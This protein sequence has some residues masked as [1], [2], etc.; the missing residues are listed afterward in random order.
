M[1]TRFLIFFSIVLVVWGLTNFY[2]F[3]RGWQAISNFTFLKNYYI[4]I[5]LILGLSYILGRILERY[6][7][8]ILTDIFIHIGTIWMAMLLYFFLIVLAVDIVRI[9]NS[10]FHFFPTGSAFISF[11]NYAFLIIVSIVFLT[12]TIG[13]INAANPVIKIID[14]TI[15]KKTSINDLNILV[16]SDI[17]LGT[18]IGSKK[19]LKIVDAI[20]TVKPDIILLA[21]DVI[22]EDVGAII[23]K[24]IGKELRLFKAKYGV[25]AVPGNHEYIT[26]IEPAVKYLTEHNI[27][28]LRDT[29][30]LIDN[31]FYLIGRDDRSKNGFN[32]GK[33]KNLSE[34]LLNINKEY[35]LIILDHQPFELNKVAEA[36]IDLQI[37]GH[38]HHGQLW[39]FNYVT[40][41]VYELSWGYKLKESSHFYVSS[42][43]GTWGPPVRLGNR[44]EIVNININF[45]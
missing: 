15:N 42:G 33:R 34:S 25:Y 43:F 12:V 28:V 18:L 31:S 27:N 37:S 9:F 6:N 13:L 20:E 7:C 26:G 3:I 2:V 1:G 40:Q 17:H 45:K 22:D 10:F 14:I 29:S 8:N 11:K 41:K 39:P 44:S 24:D 32:N 30:V 16:V 19:L 35:P 23:Q 5:I 38:T 36:G 4:G 21:G